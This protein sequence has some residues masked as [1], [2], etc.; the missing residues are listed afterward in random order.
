[1]PKSKRTVRSVTLRGKRFAFKKMKKIDS[2]G[3][4]G[5]CDDPTNP[6]KAIKIHKSL[7]GFEELE[8]TIHEMLH[9]CF[10]DLDESVIDQVGVD[11]SKAL[12][13][14]GY[15]KTDGK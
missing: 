6:G 3:S 12:W 4:I 2:V 8:V 15:R 10:W 9:G 5:E 7:K 11:I 1:M 14:L 13:R